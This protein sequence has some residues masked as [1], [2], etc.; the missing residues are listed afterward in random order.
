MVRCEMSVQTNI[1]GLEHRILIRPDKF[2]ADPF[3]E[4]A[5]SES[6]L[7][8]IQIEEG[9]LSQHDSVMMSGRRSKSGSHYRVPVINWS[10]SPLY[11][12]FTSHSESPDTLES[13]NSRYTEEEVE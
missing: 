4:E 1:K 2:D 10:E 12:Y 3:K 8:Q 6:G 11:S 13:D 5:P 7:E 9:N